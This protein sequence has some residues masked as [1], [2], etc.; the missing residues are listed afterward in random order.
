[1]LALISRVWYNA[2]AC[3]G[4]AIIGDDSV[5][6]KQLATGIIETEHV[7]TLTLTRRRIGTRHVKSVPYGSSSPLST[8]EANAH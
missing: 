6:A 1:M 7:E 3:S 5:I 8:G 4:C 2:A